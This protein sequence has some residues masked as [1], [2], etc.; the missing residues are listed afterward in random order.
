[1]DEYAFRTLWSKTRK[2]RCW[3]SGFVRS[4]CA[5]LLLFGLGANSYAAGCGYAAP[6]AL[7]KYAPALCFFDL[8][9]YSEAAASSV[10]GQN[11]AF[12]LPTGGTF[13]FNLK[14]SNGISVGG[15][16][17]N[18]PLTP[19]ATP[20]YGG[21]ALGNNN[22]YAG[23][24]GK[25]VL[26]QTVHGTTSVLTF[27]NFAVINP[28]GTP[29]VNFDF[30]AVDGETTSA[31]N[32]S[33]SLSTDGTAWN[34]IDRSGSNIVYTGLG[35]Q[36]LSWRA[37]RGN[38]SAPILRSRSPSTVVATIV[39]GGLQGMAF[40]LA[41]T[42]L[43]LA[44]NVADPYQT[45]LGR[46]GV[47]D[48]FALAITNAAGSTFD[49]RG[50]ATT[51][52]STAGTQA[53]Q[54][55]SLIYFSGRINVGEAIAAGSASALAIYNPMT[56]CVSVS[57]QTTG[58]PVNVP[59][60]TV[61]LTTLDP[62]N[63]DL[64]RCTITNTIPQPLVSISKSVDTSALPPGGDIIY[65][66][67]VANSGD[68]PAIGTVVDDAIPAGIAAFAWTCSASGGAVCPNAS[69]SGA[70]HETLATFPPRGRVVYRITATVAASPPA[71]VLNTSTANPPHGACFPDKSAP[72][73][74]ASVANPTEPIVAISKT[75]AT[76]RAVPG[77][78][79]RF[80]LG[81]RNPG[82]VG[83]NGTVVDDPIPSGLVAPFSW[84]CSAVGGAVCPSPS[85]SGAIH[86]T[87]ATFPPGS[88]VVYTI[89]AGVAANPPASV[90]NQ[91]TA[92]PPAGGVCD[93]GS[94]SSCA[95]S[96]AI[97]AAPQIGI[98]KSANP[99][100]TLMPAGSVTYTITANN[101]GSVTAPGT[102]VHDEFPAGIASATW[103]CT[104]AGGAVCP[105]ASSGGTVAPP[106]ALLDQTLATF[107]PG[108]SVTWTVL[109]TV[110]DAPPA[111]I[112]NTVRATSPDGGLCLP[113]N[114]P[115]PCQASVMN[116]PGPIVDI[117][118]SANDSV[119][120][121]GGSVGFSVSVRNSG[122]V[123]A[124]GTTLNDPLPAGITGASWSCA[125][126]G[127]AVC[128]AASG[129]G[130][131]TATIVS[132]PPGGQL[133][134]TIL[135]T[136]AAA[137]PAPTV[138][139]TATIAPPPGGVCNG[140]GANPCV[141]SVVLPVAAQIQLSKSAA[142]ATATPGGTLTWT[143][144]ITNVGS[145]DAADTLVDDPIPGGV[146]P[147]SVSWTCVAS[148]GAACANTSG[149]GALDE[150]I[151]VFPA[152]GR[153]VYTIT[154]TV[155]A[156]PPLSIVNTATATPPGDGRC[157]PANALPP[158]EA[159]TTTPT[160]ADVSIVKTVV[161]ASGNGVAEAGEQL[162]Y[163]ITLSNRGGSAA[164]GYGVTD[165]LDANTNFV[166]AS[167]GGALSG[168][169]VTWTGLTVPAGG[170]LALTVV[171]TVKSPIPPGVM[172]IANSAYRTGDPPPNC[173]TAPRPDNCTE[174]PTASAV[175]IAK[176]VADANA[177]GI[178]EPGEL[179]TYTIALTNHGGTAVTGYG[180]L[181]P[182]DANTSFVSADNGGSASGN[183]VS[184]SGLSIPAGGSLNLTLVVS[185]NSPLPAG[186]MQ[187]GNL[188]Y[189][190]G[191]V[192]PDCEALPRPAACTSI[193]TPGRV[194]IAKSVADANG[195]GLA[196][197]GEQLIY[198][199]QLSNSGGTAVAGYSVVDPLDA[200]VTFVSASDG[201]TFAG[202]S[203]TWNGL[204][205]GAGSSLTLNVVVTV[206]SPIAAGVTRIRNLAHASTD[207]PPDC[208]AV[209]QP[210]SCADIPVAPQDASVSIAK[211]ANTADLVAGGHVIYNVTVRNTGTTTAEN[212]AVSDALPAG[213][214]A[215]AWTC[216]ASGGAACPSASGSGALAQTIASL[217]IGAQL[218][219]VITATIVASPPDNIV[220]IAGVGLSN[221][222]C[223]PCSATVSGTTG[224]APPPPV[225]A[226]AAGREML[227]L[228]AT[229]LAAIA[230]SMRF[231]RSRR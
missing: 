87:L 185:V 20:T 222:S 83:A 96:A 16:S 37:P 219:Y 26:Y 49:L 40:A 54:A 65:T 48:Q 129:S 50:R 220:N 62:G 38:A 109:A 223:A 170:T 231:V 110:N 150:S 228:L 138:V 188:A 106:A 154:A 125:A 57:G 218:I 227:W 153:L 56:S 10:A 29:V 101:G 139:N 75:A 79:V 187:I 81:V 197:P 226:P 44:K 143:V 15:G 74:A 171:V 158:C 216:S 224:P 225:P 51:T 11:F 53:A 85:G 144:S 32:E 182:L 208:N 21:A 124:D 114:T 67:T 145:A 17:P 202:G 172:Q 7:G 103:T 77:S 45:G 95:A 184:W 88:E 146:D 117:A 217:P 73:C 22:W 31:P 173:T 107:P 132:F 177:N 131:I 194:T 141:A 213:I 82:S 149:S 113:G 168:G 206:K 175:L 28:D 90:V 156:E 33:F 41:A 136:V 13:S 137:P 210:A 86:Q 58:L 94:A 123:A 157:A 8:S 27:S 196:E 70:I 211:T 100:G 189:H 214:D 152:G 164:T 128:P 71:S 5:F 229:L 183:T 64:I 102:L 204:N 151:A 18:A 34:E 160:A 186:V 120:I 47:G 60:A 63:F 98:S 43:S 91:A 46:A 115:A 201:G 80:A 221:G 78:T 209:P 165:P 52:G 198:T 159:D 118:K 30:V 24:P 59:G 134:Y 230:G 105:A 180:V 179:L 192:P 116:S 161:D 142:P 92:T 9:D 191:D 66:V 174:I 127:G 155:S 84:T 2:Q 1:M 166:S 190:T 119:A 36:N 178:A 203:V 39:G 4:L 25:P 169:A 199:I 133:V 215:F 176:S 35:T 163:T 212:V 104:A 19:S 12:T 111:Q 200:N 126:S 14:R 121:P 69:G 135:A 55:Q 130:A 205:I 68:V 147:A 207:A 99:N 162:T 148:N 93:D 122:S 97:P 89:T 6:T 108:S 167:N 181:D 112:V 72:P 76:A 42:S 61:G 193:P 140:S 23:I 195:N 3:C